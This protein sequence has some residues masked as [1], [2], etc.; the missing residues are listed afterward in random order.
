MQEIS[1]TPRVIPISR[2]TNT[3]H[4]VTQGTT[5]KPRVRMI[6]RLTRR[7]PGGWPRVAGHCPVSNDGVGPELSDA[8]RS[9]GHRQRSLHLPLPAGDG[10]PLC[11]WGQVLTY[12]SSCTQRIGI[13][14][15]STQRAVPF[16]RWQLSRRIGFGSLK[17]EVRI[18]THQHQGKESPAESQYHTL[19]KSEPLFAVSTVT[20]H[21]APLPTP[22]RHMVNAILHFNPQGPSHPRSQCRMSY[23]QRSRNECRFSLQRKTTIRQ[24]ILERS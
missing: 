20:H 6:H 12:N 11:H 1:T 15:A 4:D 24:L 14:C 13:R 23:K 5:L 21:D 17:E 10:M 2:H 22:R 3:L 8:G 7:L 19:Q 18:I 16:S 9:K